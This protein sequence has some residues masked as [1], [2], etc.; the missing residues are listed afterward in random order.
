MSYF[1]ELPNISYSSR[2]SEKN[3]GEE[4]VEVKNIFK[5][6]KLRSDIDSAI[7]AFTYYKVSEGER[8][9]TLAKKI[10]ND[11]ELDWVILITNNITN[12]RDQWPLEG[13]SFTN[14]L[15][16]KYGTSDM[17]EEEKYAELSKV[18][19]Y[20]TTEVKDEYDRILL[21]KGAI[22]DKDFKFTF[23]KEVTRNKTVSEITITLP[24]AASFNEGDS[25]RQPNAVSGGYTFTGASGIVKTTTS[26]KS[27]VIINQ[28]V[29]NFITTPSGIPAGNPLLV[30]GDILTNSGVSGNPVATS[31]KYKTNTAPSTINPVRGV[32]Y[33][34]YEVDMN[35]KKRRIK[36]L[37]PEYLSVFISDMRGIMQY[38][39]SSQYVNQK[40]KKTY[41]PDSVGV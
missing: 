24:F 39:R 30:N 29:G 5:R 12:V 26:N 18:K 35:E 14:Y 1:R 16:S 9:D 37:K 11:S 23:T 6:A 28:V 17:T 40:V 15:L 21:E 3:K 25:I 8:P 7:T 32:T 4:T 36:V 22:V 2:F 34:D 41:N 27:T 19:H 13:M 10:Y 38:S 31:I 33:Y 20:E